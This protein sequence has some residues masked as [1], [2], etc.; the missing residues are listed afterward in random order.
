MFKILRSEKKV[1]CQ[2]TLQLFLLLLFSNK[3]QT[4]LVEFQYILFRNVPQ[5]TDFDF[6]WRNKTQNKN[7][8]MHGRQTNDERC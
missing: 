6:V 3:F 4:N 7:G 8:Y 5:M 2:T 1:D